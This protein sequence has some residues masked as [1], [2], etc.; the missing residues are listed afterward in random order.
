VSGEADEARTRHLGFYL[1]VAERARPEL[2]G[3]AQGAWLARLDLERENLL[4]AHAWCDRVE[5]G[6]ERG[7]Q[8]AYFIKPYWFIRGLLGLGH[9]VMIEALAR[10]GAQKRS[11]ARC[12]G[13]LDV[14][15]IDTWRGRYVEALAHLEEGLAIAR[16]LGDKP[17]TAAL[18]QPLGLA[19]LGNGD[20]AAARAYLAEA[21]ALAHEL[22]NKRELLAAHNALAQLHRAEGELDAA[23]PLYERTLTLAREMGDREST[24]IGLLNLAMVSIG[25]GSNERAGRMLLEVLDIVDEIGSQSAGQSALE[26]SAGLAARQNEWAKAARLYGAAEAQAE[27]TGLHRDPADEAFLAPLIDAARNALPESAYTAAE[28]A[29]RALAYEEALLEARAWL[30]TSG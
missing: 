1:A 21:L 24:A 13:L 30:V 3:P 16:E 14:G 20:P 7:L 9:R 6:A 19:A 10:T 2:A 18:L 28:V 4:A 11:I 15:Q 12:G 26:V 8:L 29:G 22:G 5:D 17:M 23:E 27:R 25:R